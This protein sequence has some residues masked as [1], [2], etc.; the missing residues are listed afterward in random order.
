MTTP[1]GGLESLARGIGEALTLA[2]LPSADSADGLAGGY[3]FALLEGQGVCVAWLVHDDANTSLKWSTRTL[4][5]AHPSLGFDDRA[6]DV[7]L[8]A[9][10]DLLYSA[11]FTIRLTA[12]DMESDRC[13]ALMV[14]EGPT[15][16]GS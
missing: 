16:R 15:R 9:M 6:R 3:S 14:T 10:T 1:R 5:A 4:D 2:G 12:P 7:M 8:R 13:T 11:G